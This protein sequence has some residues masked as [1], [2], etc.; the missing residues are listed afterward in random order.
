[1]TDDTPLP[2]SDRAWVNSL[3]TPERV[4]ASAA[5][6]RMGSNRKALCDGW[7]QL[8]WTYVTSTMVMSQAALAKLLK[9]S[10]RTVAARLRKPMDPLTIMVEA[11]RD[12][13]VGFV[14]DPLLKRLR[15]GKPDDDSLDG[16]RWKVARIL[17]RDVFDD[18]VAA[19]RAA[20]PTQIINDN[21]VQQLTFGKVATFDAY[22]KQIAPKAP[23]LEPPGE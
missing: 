8:T 5:M 18:A 13:L 22:L 7:E 11:A 21:R 15:D 9:V 20:R 10:P 4:A 12:Y 1:M 14:T 6:K 2:D 16:L 3:P 23:A 17:R 19:A